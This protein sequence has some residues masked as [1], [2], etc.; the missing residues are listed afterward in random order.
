MKHIAREIFLY[1]LVSAVAFGVDLLILVGL[2]EIAGA[3]YLAA[4]VAGFVTGGLVAYGLCVRFIFRYRRIEDRRVEASSFIVLGLAGLAVNTAG[5]FVG[6]ELFGVHY[7]LAKI[8]AAG[9]S[10]VVN[11]ALRRLALFT[12]PSSQQTESTEA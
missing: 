1:G 4:A 9:L 5:I 12:P 3:P 8:G 11:Y 7:L 6:V 10:F 2:V